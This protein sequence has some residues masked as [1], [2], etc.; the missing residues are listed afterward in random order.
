MQTQDKLTCLTAELA[1]FRHFSD[2]LQTELDQLRGNA[3]HLAQEKA[4]LAAELAAQTSAAN[5][6]Q[7]AHDELTT[8][9]QQLMSENAEFGRQ[10]GELGRRLEEAVAAKAAL[11][12]RLAAN[13]A[14]DSER[15]AAAAAQLQAAREKADSLR[16]KLQ[17]LEAV[18]NL[19]ELKV[20]VHSACK[21]VFE[22]RTIENWRWRHGITN[23]TGFFFFVLISVRSFFLSFQARSSHCVYRFNTKNLFRVHI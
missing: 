11:E 5:R 23:K 16:Q 8:R 10:S 2:S 20:S 7:L 18:S 14:V 6:L 19:T 15:A 1:K 17:Q 4:T 13:A 9:Q 3:A 22:F 12:A 21:F